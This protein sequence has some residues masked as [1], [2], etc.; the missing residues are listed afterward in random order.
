MKAIV[1]FGLPISEMGLSPITLTAIIVSGFIFIIAFIL[2]SKNMDSDGIMKWMME[3]PKDW[4][5]N[6]KN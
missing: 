6:K 3:K 1:I 4:V 2:S 5:G